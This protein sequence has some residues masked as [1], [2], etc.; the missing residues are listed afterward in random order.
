MLSQENRR[1]H[2]YHVVQ[3]IRVFVQQPGQLLLAHPFELGEVLVRH[4]VPLLGGAPVVI[5]NRVEHQV[6]IVPAK[7]SVP[8]ADIKP[9]QVNAVD[10][11]LARK[12]HQAVGSGGQVVEVPRVT[13]VLLLVFVNY[14]LA[15]LAEAR[16]ILTGRDVSRVFNFDPVA[17]L[18]VHHLPKSALNA[19]VD[20]IPFLSVLFELAGQFSELG[21]GVTNRIL[22]KRSRLS[23]FLH[24]LV[25]S[26]KFD[27]RIKV[28]R[29]RRLEGFGRDNLD[30][31]E[32]SNVL[33]FHKHFY[34]LYG[35]LELCQSRV[36]N[37]HLLDDFQVG[38]RILRFD[39]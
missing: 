5:V 20:V 8:H 10:V 7:S 13:V 27:R 4:A 14:F 19:L 34:V 39:P 23:Q 15:C 22:I 2:G 26:R 21:E 25:A 28:E 31:A 18:V 35:V 38:T 16:A 9:G 6:F 29:Q 11:V 3:Q 1:H 37:G 24:N 36:E 30:A 32:A 17:L 33:R 12:L